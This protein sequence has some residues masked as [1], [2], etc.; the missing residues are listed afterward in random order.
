MI[1]SCEYRPLL[2][3]FIV[4]HRF[5]SPRRRNHH[6]W[7]VVWPFPL[8]MI[9]CAYFSNICFHQYTLQQVIIFLQA[10][11]SP[12]SFWDTSVF[13]ASLIFLIL[14]YNI[15]PKIA[16]EELFNY[17]TNGYIFLKKMSIETGKLHR[18]IGTV[19]H[20]SICHNMSSQLPRKHSY[21]TCWS[22]QSSPEL[23]R[24]DQYTWWMDTRSNTPRRTWNT[25]N[26]CRTH[27][28]HIKEIK[29]SGKINIQEMEKK[30]R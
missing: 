29:G 23:Y 7:M 24:R 9:Q 11:I 27:H 10:S 28:K 30:E 1:Y 6:R 12:I 21:R 13:V 5:N 20:S 22:C 25:W 2:L 14:R 16:K 4:L 15:V 18:G 17:V 8:L 3:R 26:L 19:W